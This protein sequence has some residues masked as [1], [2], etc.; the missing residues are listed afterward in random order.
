[1]REFSLY[2]SKHITKQQC[3]QTTL[4]LHLYLIFFDG[5]SDGRSVI[6]SFVLCFC[7]I[8]LVSTVG[9]KCCLQCCCR[10][11]LTTYGCFYDKRM[12]KIDNI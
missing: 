3:S 7:S 4:L 2:L 11:K 5:N 10:K 12:V 1:M 9:G 8:F 6:R